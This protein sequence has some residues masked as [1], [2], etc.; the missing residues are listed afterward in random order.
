[1]RKAHWDDAAS[2]FVEQPC[3]CEQYLGD[4]PE[5]VSIDP[6]PTGCPHEVQEDLNPCVC[7]HCGQRVQQRT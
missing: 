1:M 4:F 7:V 6:S 3:D 5:V 2:A